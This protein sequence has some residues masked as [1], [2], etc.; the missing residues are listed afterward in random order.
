MTIGNFA[1]ILLD[2]SSIYSMR[3]VYAYGLYQGLSEFDLIKE[4]KRNNNLSV[5][6]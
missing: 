5:T 3:H 2:D 4:I 1:S 6:S